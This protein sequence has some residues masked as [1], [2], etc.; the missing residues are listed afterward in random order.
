VDALYN[1]LNP[2]S[3][4]GNVEGTADERSLVY[5]TGRHGK[6]KAL[7][8][9][10]FDPAIKLAGLKRWTGIEEG[11]CQK[12]IREGPHI[13]R[14]ANSTTHSE[15]FEAPGH[16]VDGAD[17]PG[18]NGKGKAQVNIGQ[19]KMPSGVGTPGDVRKITQ[20][21]CRGVGESC[22][23]ATEEKAMYQD[24]RLGFYFGHDCSKES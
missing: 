13:A 24:R 14:W 12:G 9:V 23:W 7:V 21:L 2:S 19:S 8:F 11:M 5:A 22:D 3:Y 18:T 17:R 6:P 1:L 10:G 16:D 15:R 20:C 4:L